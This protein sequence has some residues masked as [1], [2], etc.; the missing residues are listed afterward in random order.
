MD[1]YHFEEKYGI[2]PLDPSVPFPDSPVNI[3]RKKLS[4][5]EFLQYVLWLYF[6]NTGQA[7]NIIKNKAV[8][9]DVLYQNAITVMINLD[10]DIK[11]IVREIGLDL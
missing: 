2:V 1:E 5:R 8:K 3:K 9:D 11:R 6:M 10:S 4:Q 7:V